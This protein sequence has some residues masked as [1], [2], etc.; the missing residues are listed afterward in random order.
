MQNFVVF[1]NHLLKVNRSNLLLLIIFVFIVEHANSQFYSYKTITNTDNPPKLKYKGGL[2]KFINDSITW[3][4][5]FDGIGNV[6]ALF[7]V[8]KQGCIE[9]IRITQKLCPNCD[10]EVIR[11]LKKLP[12]WQAGK[13]DNKNIDVE[14][15]CTIRFQI[16][17]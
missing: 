2:E 15:E 13:L 11:I 5:S 4:A 1:A 8:T 16:S 9:N 14:I 12:R 6:V 7:T 10:N 17:E 3:P